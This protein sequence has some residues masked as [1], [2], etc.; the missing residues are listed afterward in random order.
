MNNF[1]AVLSQSRLN[2]LN[3]PNTNPSM[4]NMQTRPPPIVAP[5]LQRPQP[6]PAA[7]SGEADPAIGDDLDEGGGVEPHFELGRRQSTRVESRRS[8]GVLN[9]LDYVAKENDQD[10]QDPAEDP[11]RR[12]LPQLAN[13]GAKA[14]DHA[15]SPSEVTLRK[16]SSSERSAGRSSLTRMFA[17]TSAALMS[18]ALS[19][20]AATRR[21]PSTAVTAFEPSIRSSSL[22][23]A[24]IGAART[25][26][27]GSPRSPSTVPSPTS[28]PRRPMPTRPPTCSTPP[29]TW[30][31][32][33]TVPDPPP[34]PRARPAPPPTT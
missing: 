33:S 8:G 27:A 24:S 18:A 17:S 16:T 13:F 31:E 1:S 7:R 20:V 22:R 12:T 28:L 34:A 10:E 26:T 5:A 32:G 9:P 30:L 2:P 21:G 29:K 23:A 11:D 15:A 3:S 25:V 6:H 4:L 19:C 14:S